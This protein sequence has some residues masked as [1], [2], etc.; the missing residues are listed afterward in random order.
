MAEFEI[1]TNPM[2]ITKDF[3]LAILYTPSLAPKIM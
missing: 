2:A 3:K 1:V